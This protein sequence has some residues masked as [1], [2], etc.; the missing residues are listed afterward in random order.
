MGAISPRAI[1]KSPLIRTLR[2]TE[3][4][5]VF[6]FSEHGSYENARREPERGTRIPGLAR[7]ARVPESAGPAGGNEAQAGHRWQSE[8]R[9]AMAARPRERR[10][11]ISLVFCRAAYRGSRERWW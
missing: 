6:C 4:R 8:P 2:A 1:S 5:R 10:D 11:R 3:L 9:F 7:R